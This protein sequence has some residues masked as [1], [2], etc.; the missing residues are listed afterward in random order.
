[1]TAATEIVH[2]TR[3][4]GG[5]IKYVQT[6]QFPLKPKS[7]PYTLHEIERAFSRYP[8]ERIAEYQS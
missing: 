3:Y 4:I 5:L 2:E 7:K 1:V 6:L 8:W